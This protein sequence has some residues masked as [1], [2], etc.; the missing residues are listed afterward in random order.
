[1]II[2]WLE[3]KQCDLPLAEIKFVRKRISG[4]FQK[5]TRPFGIPR[6]R[7]ILI[8]EAK[9]NFRR[10]KITLMFIHDHPIPTPTPPNPTTNPKAPAGNSVYSESFALVKALLKS[11]PCKEIH[12]SFF[13]RN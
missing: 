6:R 4:Q 2:A 12:I 3:M 7:V 11:N 8:N 13:D 1:M 5:N 9:G 10:E